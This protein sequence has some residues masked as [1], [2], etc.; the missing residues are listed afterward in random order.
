MPVTKMSKIFDG[1]RYKWNIRYKKRSD[2]NAKA[3]RL[4]KNYQLARVVPEKL[5]GNQW[6]SVYSR[7]KRRKK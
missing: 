6:Y 7:Q 1:K 5:H 4:R 2:A 3:K